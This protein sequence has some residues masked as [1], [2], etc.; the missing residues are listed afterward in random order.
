MHQ[1]PGTAP[2]PKGW[3]QI[4]R[5]APP[6]PCGGGG[7]LEGI[8]HSCRHWERYIDL[9]RSAYNMHPYACIGI[10]MYAWTCNC[11]GI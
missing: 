9:Y 6:T 2:P 1:G 7:R 4:F 10:Q 5:M 11:R 3:G 8:V